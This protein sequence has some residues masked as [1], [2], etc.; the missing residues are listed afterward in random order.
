VWTTIGAPHKLYNSA[1][2]NYVS[3]AQR[4]RWVREGREADKAPDQKRQRTNE[5]SSYYEPSGPAVAG[6]SW[7][8]SPLSLVSPSSDP[9][10]SIAAENAEAD[11]INLAANPQ[12]NSNNNTAQNKGK[13][14]VTVAE[15]AYEG[16]GN[17]KA[18]TTTNQP[19]Y[20]AKAQPVP[21]NPFDRRTE[22]AVRFSDEEDFH[23]SNIKNKVTGNRG[24]FKLINVTPPSIKAKSEVTAMADTPAMA[25]APASSSNSHVDTDVAMSD[26]IAA[27]TTTTTTARPTADVEAAHALLGF[28]MSGRVA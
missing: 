9:F 27:T 5:S 4:N 23:S 21:P 12:G 20:N 2:V 15:N 1:H 19:L 16:K 7:S 3:N 18:T 14:K 26:N 24:G 11:M 25:D 13:S 10:V 8:P 22:D 28:G 6:P 17:G